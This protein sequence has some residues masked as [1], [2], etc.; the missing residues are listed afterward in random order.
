M[1]YTFKLQ[2]DQVKKLEDWQ[3]K[4]KEEHGEYGVFTYSFTPYGM[5]TGVKVRSHNT[6]KTL[7]LSDVDNW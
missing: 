7:N 3:K 5:G 2:P 1:E 6:K 4:I